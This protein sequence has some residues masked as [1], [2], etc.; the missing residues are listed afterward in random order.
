MHIL[1]FI[2]RILYLL[3]IDFKAKNTI[4]D[5][6][7]SR[8]YLQL[9]KLHEHPAEELLR[10]CFFSWN[11]IWS[12][13]L[14]FKQQKEFFFVPRVQ[15]VESVHDFCCSATIYCPTVFGRFLSKVDTA[16][17]HS[18]ELSSCCF[19]SLFSLTS[20]IPKSNSKTLENRHQSWRP[21]T[22]GWTR[23]P[24]CGKAGK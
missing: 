12:L 2:H 8:R 1:N 21:A 11:A 4:T 10:L 22:V 17:R 5:K 9:Y 6:S 13:V 18:V 20:S 15:I 19:N 16:K 23:R 14:A 24:A 3:A 7:R